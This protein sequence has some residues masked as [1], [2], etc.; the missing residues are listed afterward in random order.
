VSGVN[1]LAP[2][3]KVFINS[4]GDFLKAQITSTKQTFYGPV[5]LDHQKQVLKRIQLLTKQDFPE[6][7]ID[8][9]NDGWVRK[10]TK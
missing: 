8:I 3:I 1:G 6:S 9:D 7:K 5:M 4:K 2:I 10:S